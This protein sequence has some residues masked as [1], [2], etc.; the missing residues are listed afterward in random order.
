[1]G[2]LLTLVKGFPGFL[3]M[4]CSYQQLLFVQVVVFVVLR[5]LQR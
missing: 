1:M 4:L 2:T 5:A 3:G